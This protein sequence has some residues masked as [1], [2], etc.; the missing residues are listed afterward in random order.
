[1]RS[2]ASDVRY[3]PYIGET[4]RK[5]ADRFGEHLRSVEGFNHNSRYHGG[6][7]PA[8]EHFNLVDHKNIPDMKVSVVKQVNAG[9]APGQREEKRLSSNLKRLLPEA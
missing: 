3:M 5:L 6:D 1:M 7:F 4:S 2:F 9:T 8:A